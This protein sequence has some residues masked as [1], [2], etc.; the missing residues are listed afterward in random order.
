MQVSGSVI[1]FSGQDYR[2][3]AD[4]NEV[5]YYLSAKIDKPTG[6]AVFGFSGESGVTD[7]KFE[8]GKIID[9]EDRFVSSYRP[10]KSFSISGNISGTHYDYS[11]DGTKICADGTR[12]ESRVE[13]FFCHTTGCN[14]TAYSLGIKTKP[15]EYNFDLSTG[16]N[17]SGIL[18]GKV[19]SSDGISR[20]KIFNAE[21][22]NAKSLFEVSGWDTGDV[23]DSTI[24]ISTTGNTSSSGR[25]MYEE[26]GVTQYTRYNLKVR[27]DTNFGSREKYFTTHC[28]PEDTLTEVFNL[29]DADNNDY[30]ISGTGYVDSGIYNLFYQM[31]EEETQKITN[32]PLN[33]TLDYASG[34]TGQFYTVSTAAHSAS[35]SGYSEIP[36]LA[37]TGV[38][39]IKG[40]EIIPLMAFKTTGVSLTY[41]GSGYTAAPTLS[42]TGGGG[43]NAAG[44]VT[45]YTTG[46][47][48][49]TISGITM[50]NDGSSYT[51]HPDITFEGAAI[52]SGSGV[53][54]L[55]SGFLTGVRL[56]Y[57]GGFHVYEPEVSGVKGGG[58]SGAG[59]AFTITTSGYDKDFTGY[60]RIA[61]GDGLHSL[62]DYYME[63]GIKYP[64]KDGYINSP[65]GL[66]T[67]GETFS[68]AVS[69]HKNYPD[70]G[71]M[72]AKLTVSGQNSTTEK[73]ITG[74][75]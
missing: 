69:N 62:T 9:S 14:L 71:K 17:L 30:L 33:I 74:V 47:V 64:S 59:A 38:N 58:P 46:A 52:Q 5:S 10:N 70:S 1:I 34:A 25:G 53:A 55:G 40:D 61:T 28:K 51:G 63:N 57:G 7:F 43:A 72:Y 42:I 11:I 27:I 29:T 75:A 15:F 67:S 23:T 4:R 18:T 21:I 66:H 24:Y 35:G 16:F 36:E 13:R 56:D 20:F 60:W 32:K 12:A 6:V 31:Y 73:I 3:I 2:S 8:S 50:T 54:M 19:E 26:T 65:T 39:E 44:T 45:I 37:V 48:S 68:I 49:G 22:V 41:G